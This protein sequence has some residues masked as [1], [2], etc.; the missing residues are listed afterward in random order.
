[1]PTH[2]VGS[3]PVAIRRFDVIGQD[4][5]SEPGFIGHVALAEEDR[6]N[7]NSPAAVPV[8]HMR[9]PFERPGECRADCVGSAGLSVRRQRQ[10]KVF[11]DMIGSEYE[12]ARLGK[13]IDQYIIDPHV[14]PVRRK[15]KTV[16]C[17]R[18]SC[19]GLVIEAYRA[20]QIDILWTDLAPVPLVERD[21]LK[22]QYPEF[23]KVLDRP[24]E[25]KKLGIP[26]DG[27]WPVILA[28]YVLNALDRPESEIHKTPYLPRAGDEFF[29][30][31][32][33]RPSDSGPISIPWP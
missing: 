19:V 10:I 20:A 27:P 33:P 24:R 2:R 4:S 29:P 16:V 5:S 30:P 32:R 14:W 26:G 9:P 1:M 25:R 17:H 15:D 31:R 23:A 13:S 18:F 21:A 8:V 12:A 22:T 6:V 11:C 28:G 3:T 7:H